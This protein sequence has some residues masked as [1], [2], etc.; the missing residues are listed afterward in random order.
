MLSRELLEKVF[1]KTA[2]ISLL[3]LLTAVPLIMVTYTRDQFELPKLTA[4]RVIILFILFLTTWRIL[5]RKK[6]TWFNTA[7]D[8]PLL[9]LFL[10][11]TVTTI[12]SFS[13]TTSLYGDYENFAGLLSFLAYIALFYLLFHTIKKE[14]IAR[15]ICL[16]LS[17]GTLTA[18]YALAQ[19]YGYD[20]VIWEATSMIR[21]RAFSCL[22]NPNFLAAYLAVLMPFF[23]YFLIRTRSTHLW[24]FSIFLCAGLASGMGLLLIHRA[25]PPQ[26]GTPPS[27][28]LNLLAVILPCLILAAT[29]YFAAKLRDRHTEKKPH[30]D[31]QIISPWPGIL[32][33]AVF[34]IAFMVC[35]GALLATSS[36]GGLLALGTSLLLLLGLLI[37]KAPR[38]SARTLVLI[39]LLLLLP[40]GYISYRYG[41]PLIKRVQQ[42]IQT[43]SWKTEKS[44][45]HI[46]LPAL[47]TI[48]HHPLL[49]SG[50]DTFKISFPIYNDARFSHIDGMFVSSRTAH[51]EFLQFASTM[52]LPTLGFYLLFLLTAIRLQFSLLKRST[53]QGDAPLRASLLAG[54]TAYL[55][56]SFVS[57]GVVSILVIFWALTAFSLAL[58]RDR[59]KINKFSFRIPELPGLLLLPC[60]AILT[61]HCLNLLAA[62]SY[63][64]KAQNFHRYAE[65]REKTAA[66]GELSWFYAQEH[67]LMKKSISLAPLEVKYHVYAGLAA[68]KTYRF[69]Q[70]DKWW[71]TAKA[72]YQRSLELSPMNSYYYNNLARLH[73]QYAGEKPIGHLATAEK[74]YLQAIQLAPATAFFRCML[75]DLYFEI[76][77]DKKGLSVLTNALELNAKFTA[78]QYTRLFLK[79]FQRGRTELAETLIRT[80]LLHFPDDA[81]ANYYLAYA[82]FV[83]N[84][85]PESVKYLKKALAINPEHTQAREMLEN[86]ESK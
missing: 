69:D 26:A 31:R 23:P 42:D 55:V 58:D 35:L 28:L 18:C 86:L 9:L 37:W 51:N 40:S 79:Y 81:D 5:V 1:R 85:R 32:H 54:W 72:N 57:F 16:A 25:F 39:S 52:G 30:N 56:Q 8:L 50:L 46:W 11:H 19:H 48:R 2:R 60:L 34:G 84:Q 10:G 65:S 63:F 43:F 33:R 38:P 68:E 59:L 47:R 82:L 62:D 12:I 71:Q 24:A 75:A 13:P 73:Q 80:G 44:R 27:T 76:G 14:D 53:W 41:R 64:Q 67:Q 17:C 70:Q 22:G 3:Y 61:L 6:G 45:L 66:A 21:G 20:L 29:F 49:G 77:N 36:R 83:R 7:L 4:V 78:R 15:F 74:N